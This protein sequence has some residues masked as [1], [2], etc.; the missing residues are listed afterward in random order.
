MTMTI[1]DFLLGTA[2]GYLVLW[3]TDFARAA[4]KDRR[5]RATRAEEVRIARGGKLN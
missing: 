5:R 4:L 2:V 3:S 1:T